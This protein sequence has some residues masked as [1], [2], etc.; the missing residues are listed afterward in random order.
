MGLYGQLQGRKHKGEKLD[1]KRITYE[2]LYK[3]WWKE[4]CTD[5]M[6]AELYDV[7]KKKVT[8]LRHKWGVKLPDTILNE[9]R[10]RFEGKIPS[11]EEDKARRAVSREKVV[12][13]QKIHDLND[14]ELE[15][16]SLEL[17]RLYPAFAE[18]K[19]EADFFAEIERAVR[20]FTN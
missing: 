15:A 14:G 9:F 3:L 7:Q 1:I 17:A 8:N 16:L 6:I 12:L 4:E 11:V 2:T 13:L 10:D 18:I 20:N 19:Q 5:G